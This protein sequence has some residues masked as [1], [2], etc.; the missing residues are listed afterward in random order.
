[1][2]LS[3]S[4]LTETFDKENSDPS[5]TN[6]KTSFMSDVSDITS[7]VK[8]KNVSGSHV[9]Q[10][11]WYSPSGK[12][13]TASE[14][15][16]LSITTGNYSSEVDLWHQLS[17]DGD[18]AQTLPGKWKLD[19]LLDDELK[20]THFFKVKMTVNKKESDYFVNVDKGI[21]KTAMKNKNAIAVIIGNSKYKYKDVPDVKYAINDALVMK[22]YL[23][24]TL[25]YRERNI[26]FRKNAT[27]SE[28]NEIFGIKGNHKGELYNL[29]KEG[30]SEVF[31]YYSGHGAPDLRT[32]KGFFIPYDCK[33][34]S[35]ALN[36]YPLNLFYENLS[37]LSAKKTTIILDACFSGGVNSGKNLI[38]NASPIGIRVK[39]PIVAMGNAVCM[40][41][42]TGDQVSSW[43]KK[44]KHGLFTYYFLLALRGKADSNGDKKITYDE[45]YKYVADKHDGVPYYARRNYG[46]EQSPTIQGM[47]VGDVFVDLMPAM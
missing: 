46:R 37:K 5:F 29:I 41:S 45:V 38:E 8:L 6:P 15:L 17:M 30:L 40:A 10:W 33:S 35:I 20:K 25:G 31:V 32:K 24:E 12:L 3:K 39:N 13:Y 14:K 7:V 18:K 44:G 28:F 4:V 19:F 22:K 16:P 36:G 2:K 23:I 47:N 34:T 42:S 1:M 21:I 26:I 43:H 11:K 27:K 9:A